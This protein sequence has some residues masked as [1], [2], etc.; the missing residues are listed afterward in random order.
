MTQKLLVNYPW[1]VFRW[2]RSFQPSFERALWGLQP[3]IKSPAG[4]APAAPR[5][6]SQHVPHTLSCVL[7]HLS[8]PALQR[9]FSTWKILIFYV[10]GDDWNILMEKSCL[11]SAL[12]PLLCSI[13]RR[14][15]MQWQNLLDLWPT[16][17]RVDQSTFP[18]TDLLWSDT[19]VRCYCCS[20]NPT[21]GDDQGTSH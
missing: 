16:V 21:P 14:L 4:T 6:S 5:A 15:F 8:T 19:K 10:L 17:V 13:V 2:L 12:S 9:W 20:T 1:F 18:F 3:W 11:T 7:C